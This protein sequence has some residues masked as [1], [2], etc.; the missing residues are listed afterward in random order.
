MS[1][2]D[3][4]LSCNV[5][6][7][8]DNSL[9]LMIP[10]PLSYI[11]SINQQYNKSSIVKAPSLLKSYQSKPPLNPIVYVLALYLACLQKLVIIL[12]YVL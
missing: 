2:H 10:H 5:S 6:P 3:T 4:D 7:E 1:A 12:N 11:Q 8:T 9:F